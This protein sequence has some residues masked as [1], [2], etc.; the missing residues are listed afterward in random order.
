[1]EGDVS[2]VGMYFEDSTDSMEWLRDAIFENDECLWRMKIICGVSLL[3]KFAR[4]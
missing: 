2:G 4:L 1:M 3:R